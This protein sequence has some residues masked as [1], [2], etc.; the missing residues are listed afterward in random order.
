MTQQQ[1]KTETADAPDADVT[2]DVDPPEVPVHLAWNR[3]M[4]DVQAIAKGDYNKDQRFSFRGVDAVMG[5]VGPAFR[6][7]G[8]FLMPEQILELRE[9]RYQSKSGTNMHG[10]IITIRWRITGPMGDV[11]LAESSGQA[12]DSGDKVVSKAHS[13]AYRILLLQ[14]LCVPTGDPDPDAE[15][16]ERASGGQEPAQGR[17]QAA[18]P[19]PADPRQAM[20]NDILNRG[21]ERGLSVEEIRADYKSRHG[22]EIDGPEATLAELVQYFHAMTTPPPATPPAGA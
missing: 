12:A 10:V 18:T 13:V 1:R 2:P 15:S 6:K 3:V 8:V 11:M 14:G 21:K 19:P 22:H 17:G 5:A 7:H 16:H 9:E 4:R 20:W